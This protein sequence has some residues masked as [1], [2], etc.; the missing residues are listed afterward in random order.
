MK[1]VATS[2]HQTDLQKGEVVCYGDPRVMTKSPDN[3]FVRKGEV[4]AVGIGKHLVIG[5]VIRGR[6]KTYAGPGCLIDVTSPA[7][8]KKLSLHQRSTHFK[9][10]AYSA[11]KLYKIR[12]PRHSIFFS[13]FD[14]VDAGAE[15]K[16][17][18]EPDGR[19]FVEDK[20]MPTCFSMYTMQESDAIMAGTKGR[21]G[22]GP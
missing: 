18:G 15:E 22:R 20:D 16:W 9:R 5:R 1:R 19:D 7:D 13:A 10:I 2:T 12:P 17:E 11:G 3:G 4:V 8:D 6:C 14:S 21:A